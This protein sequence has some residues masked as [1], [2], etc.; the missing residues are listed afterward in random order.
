[1]SLTSALLAP[2]ASLSCSVVICAYTER[3]WDDLSAAILSLS[4][5]PAATQIIV[6]VDHNPA[7][8][9]RLRKAFPHI[10]IT[11][12]RAA[13]GLNHARNAGVAA[14]QGDII[15]FIDDDALPDAHWAERMLAAYADPTVI[16]VGGSIEPNWAGSRPNWF[17]QEFDWVVGC[18]YRGMPEQPAPVRNLIGCNMSF[19]REAFDLVGG[20]TIGRV[21][22]LALGNENDE[23]EFC[24]RLGNAVPEAKILYAPDIHVL[25]RVTAERMTARY[26]V[27]R[28]FSE[29]ISKSKLSHLVGKQKSLASER[30][31]TLRTLPSGVLRGLGDVLNGK[32]SGFARAAAILF[33]LATTVAGYGYG[34]LWLRTPAEMVPAIP[35][36]MKFDEQN[37]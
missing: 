8:A 14:A 17:P 11:E 32:S 5:Q 31:Y 20:F 10:T 3:R 19:R 35:D 25:H 18:T 23:T 12:N 15:A 29:G 26:F 30:T 1:M 28:C 13:A 27:K 21:G 24:I 2:A 4:Q 7:L 6:A 33:G 22:K 34:R 9:D 37:R 36:L 16:G